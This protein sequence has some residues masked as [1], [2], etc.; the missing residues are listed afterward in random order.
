[1]AVL[2]VRQLCYHTFGPFD[3]KVGDG[4]RVFLR[5][6]S[7]AGKSLL[8]RALADLDPHSGE[9]FVDGVE[10][11]RLPAPEWRRRVG[12]LPAESQWWHDRVGDHFPAF[13]DRAA[14]L[15]LGFTPEVAEWPVARL[16]SGEKQR[17]A[18][19]RLLANRPEVLLLDEPTANLDPENRGRVENLILDYQAERQAAVLWVTHEPDQP[20][21]L[22][23][24]VYRLVDGILE[25]LEESAE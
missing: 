24:R 20:A 14:L 13:P 7:G 6:A 9:V 2:Q 19:L 11:L 3:L 12:L 15:R 21:R 5:G 17:L 25:P 23:G 16:S 18:V 4:E 8:L 22:G 10:C 1:M